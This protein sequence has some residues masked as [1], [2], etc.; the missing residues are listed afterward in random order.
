MRIDGR[1]MLDEVT[2]ESVTFLHV[3]DN[4]ELMVGMWLVI[5]AGHIDA[6]YGDTITAQRL[7]IGHKTRAD[8]ISVA[9][10]V[11]ILDEIV[12]TDAV[13]GNACDHIAV[14]ATVDLSTEATIAEEA[15]VGGT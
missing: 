4:S 3:F 6:R 11:G 7:D 14:A 12:R 9:C 5:A 15:D 13:V 1:A 2:D 8:G 10:A